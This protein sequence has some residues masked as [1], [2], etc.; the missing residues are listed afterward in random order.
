M[1]QGGTAASGELIEEVLSIARERVAGRA[2]RARRCARVDHDQ[3]QAALGVLC[4]AAGIKEGPI[5]WIESPDAMARVTWR[6]PWRGPV[7]RA[8]IAIEKRGWDVIMAKVPENLRDA[9]IEVALAGDLTLVNSVD[10]LLTNPDTPGFAGKAVWRPKRYRMLGLGW[11]TLTDAL[12]SLLGTPYVNEEDRE[13]IRALDEVAGVALVHVAAGQSFALGEV[14]HCNLDEA[15]RWHADGGRW[16]VAWREPGS[17]TRSVGFW[18]VHGVNMGEVG[19]HLLRR[20]EDITLA[21]VMEV[22]N[23]EVRRVLCEAAG[24]DRIIA[25]AGVRLIDAAADPGNPG[26]MLE[27]YDTA[28]AFTG[29]SHHVEVMVPNWTERHSTREATNLL[30]CTNASPEPD[31]NHHRYALEVPASIESALDAAAWTF[32]K[33]GAEYAR[34][35]RA[36]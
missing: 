32:N 33:T 1:N 29:E 28:K 24:W 30:L 5:S 2:E 4:R 19:V 11:L 25:A 35:G 17:T 3:V 14:T 10:W 21:A 8:G 9:L 13:V 27:L 36:T 7:R 18:Q 22:K 15:L 20:P 12:V 34:L 26:Q 6:Q 16:A 23:S 31:G